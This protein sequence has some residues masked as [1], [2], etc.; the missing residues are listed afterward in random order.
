MR[1]IISHL[2]DFFWK[3]VDDKSGAQ[4]QLVDLNRRSFGVNSIGQDFNVNLTWQDVFLGDL[5]L[6]LW[7]TR[8]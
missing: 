6:F 7:P 1:L 2:A 3:L 4:D 5:R 8:T